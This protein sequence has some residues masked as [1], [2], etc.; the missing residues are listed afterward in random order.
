M[1]LRTFGVRGAEE[2]RGAGCGGGYRFNIRATRA[3][4]RVYVRIR[5]RVPVKLGVSWQTLRAYLV[6]FACEVQELIDAR[7]VDRDAHGGRVRQPL[8]FV[9]ESVGD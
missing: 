2:V 8:R 7:R 5:I 4:A 6:P 1:G 3:R 9:S